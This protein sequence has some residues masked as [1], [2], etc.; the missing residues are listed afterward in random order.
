MGNLCAM[1]KLFGL[2]HFVYIVVAIAIAVIL[3]F[4]FR[5]ASDTIR[6]Y[7]GIGIVSVM[8]LLVVLEFIGRIRLVDNVWENLPLNLYHIFVYVAIFTEI[9][10]RSSW[11]KFGYFVVL[12]ISVLSLFFVPNLYTSMP[13]ASISVIA[14]FLINGLLSAYSILRLVWNDE[15]I[16]KRNIIDS[17]IYVVI[18]VAIMH[19]INV[20]F[21]F[22]VL[23]TDCNYCGTMGEDFGILIGFI[24][25]LI[26]IPLVNLI[27]LLAGLV[28]V[29]FLLVLPFDILKT[30]RDRQSQYEEL[31]ALGNLKAQAKYRKTGRSQVLLRGD[32]K[33]RPTIQ[34]TTT[35][36]AHKDGFVSINKEIQV[37]RDID[38]K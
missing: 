5:Q 37:N 12:P 17:T 13:Q 16:E 35:G 23:G 1:F 19:I 14:Y 26:P 15:Y 28:G 34:K 32:E 2:S 27:P 20:I 9:T 25:K 29:E 38:K 7:L 31:V 36:T 18:F 11:V 10:K 8:G 22:A 21:R 24:D 3:F 33:A 30:R 6:K 4:A